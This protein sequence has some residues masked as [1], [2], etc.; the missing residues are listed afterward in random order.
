MREIVI[1]RLKDISK[2][3]L[4]LLAATLTTAGNAQTFVYTGSSPSSVV[5]NFVSNKIYVAGSNDV[6]AIDGASNSTATIAV[7]ASPAAMAV[8][9]ATNKIYA[10]C[11][12]NVIVIDGAT[13]GTT[14]IAMG[15]A[16]GAV[17]VNPVTN[18]IYVA[19]PGSNSVAV[20][21]G[22]TNDIATVA[23]GL[24]PGL[25]SVNPTTN[26]VYVANTASQTMTVID[27][28]TNSTAAIS[29]FATP[30][31]LA[32][33]P[34]TNTIYVAIPSSNNVTVVNGATNS[35]TVV[36]VGA[37][38]SAIAVNPVTNQIYTVNAGSSNSNA[39]TAIDGATNSTTAVSLAGPPLAIA[40][41]AVT[42]QVY[43]SGTTAINRDINVGFM[44][45]IDGSS[46]S[47]V[48]EELVD[49]PGP[50]AV[51][52]VTNRVYMTVASDQGVDVFDNAT[53]PSL[54]NVTTG[55]T[56]V[57][58][59][60]NPVTNKVYVSNSYG[61]SVTVIDGANNSAVTVPAGPAPSAMAVNPATNEIYVVNP[62]FDTVTVIDGATNSTATVPVG[63]NPSALAANPVTNKIYV[64]NA[65]SSSV[66]VIDG[67]SNSSTATVTVG[68]N[69]SAVAVNP[70]TNKIY[71]TNYSDS[72]LTVIDGVSNSKTATVPVGNA[73]YAVAVNQ[74]TNQ[75]YVTAPNTN[76]V[77]AI[78]GATNSATSIVV[79]GPA[80]ALVVNPVTNKI[81]VGIPNDVVVIDG[82]N[83][84]TT[85]IELGEFPEALAVNPATNK[86][87]VGCKTDYGP[88]GEDG[89]FV[90]DG[91]TDT[92][93]WQ[94]A[95]G[96]GTAFPAWIGVNPVTNRFYA[97]ISSTNTV[98]VWGEETIQSIPLPTGIMPL[99]DNQTPDSNPALVF[100]AAST[101][102][103]DATVPEGVYF[104]LDT[105]QNAWS[106]ATGGNPYVGALAS[107]QPGFHILFAYAVDGQQATSTS[108]GSPVIGAVQAYEFLVTGSGSLVAQTVTFGNLPS[109][110]ATGTSVNLSATANTS[111]TF[112]S[113]SSASICSVSGTTLT[114]NG[115][116]TCAV[117]AVAAETSVY[118]AA[119]TSANIIVLNSQ[120]ITFG[121]IPPQTVGEP[122][123]L[124]ATASSGLPVTFASSTMTICTVSG[125]TATFIAGGTCTITASQAGN[126]IYAAAPSVSQSFTVTVGD[127]GFIAVTPCRLVD[128]RQANGSLGGPTM[129]ANSTRSFPLPSGACGLPTTAA[130]YSLNVTVVPHTTLQYLSL[131]P[132]GQSQP[133]VSTLNS[134][135]G[136]I[137][138]NAAIVPAGT[139]GA[140]SA[141]ATDQTDVIIDVNGYFGTPGS[142]GAL[143]FVP[144]TP[145][146]VE[147][148]RN[149]T[150]TFGGPILAA[151]SSRSFPIP[152]SGC[153]I[154]STAAAYSVN[155]TVLP[156]STLAYLT[157]YPT[158]A[159][160]PYVSTLNAYNGQ[161]VANAAIVPAGNSGAMSAYVTD[162]THLITDINGYFTSTPPNPLGFNTVT[163]CRVVDTRNATGAFG[164]PIM[165]AN[166]TRSFPIPMGSCGIPASA[167]AYAFNVTVVPTSTL[168]YLSIW[169]D[170][171][172]QPTVSTLNSYN[173]QIVANAAIVPAGT[174]GAVDVY[175]TDKT[176]V[177][178]DIVGYFSKP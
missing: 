133:V 122:L 36:A 161:V 13:N 29:L 103:P 56:P 64:A 123:T 156:T 48:N 8:N 5:V 127:L 43:V 93:V 130:A 15:A 164:G 34:A 142:S 165:A 177:I 17:A 49:A 50:V 115:V 141:Y 97:V 52:P 176:Q 71:V 144:V 87:Y 7:S 9:P 3:C 53:Y 152:S 70:V 150:G 121:T 131:W 119:A 32:V 12:N 95:T 128:T 58:A 157:L 82:A 158:G 26:K 109:Q 137:V 107:L 149:A 83:H 61:N 92:V 11:A 67:A 55:S 68:A 132:T 47:I 40:L 167:S 10:A 120:T 27:G 57:S 106:A 178:I 72:T 44:A 66:T 159:S 74:V 139:S 79:G 110:A 172:T 173:G 124:T 136:R 41:D 151:G 146:R 105:R 125:T 63:P 111:V 99:G 116:G 148:T 88:N 6:I 112:S 96:Y 171:E 38:P 147:D 153:A 75:I 21:D 100:T 1:C 39:V 169:P 35:I 89:L 155:A 16:A 81:Y 129:S 113:L 118:Q 170:G 160:L 162:Q 94:A 143:T 4:V 33:N 174:A 80:Y 46:N 23:V 60:I 59:A 154:P 166:S 90:I 77:T 98:S 163:P 85:T 104:Q 126:G 175:V 2:L 18:K 138:A 30:G 86:I 62:G 108:M 140:I 102:S 28:A 22:V 20:I 69:P 25:L 134:F 101:F 31:A 117:A 84:S 76:S 91:I 135:D 78:D 73:P 14:A 114:F 45:V 65:D 168:G 37:S 145:C 51:N 19:I 54:G 24:S 42:N